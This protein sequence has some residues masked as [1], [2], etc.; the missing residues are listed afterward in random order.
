ML[1]MR[2]FVKH[3]LNFNQIDAK[4]SVDNNNNLYQLGCLTES[5]FFIFRRR[6]SGALLYIDA[7]LE[8]KRVTKV[9]IFF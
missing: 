9:E 3:I 1:I 6:C 8:K 7:Q 5:L 2:Q 4:N